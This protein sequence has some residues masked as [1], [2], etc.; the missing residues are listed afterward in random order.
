MYCPQCRR[1]TMPIEHVSS[2]AKINKLCCRCLQKPQVE[3]IY[4]EEN[5]ESIMNLDLFPVSYI[6]LPREVLEDVTME[7][8]GIEF[9]DLLYEKY[10]LKFR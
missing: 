5:L 3:P 1:F 8:F 10:K 7:E 2:T 6:I 9:V 4:M